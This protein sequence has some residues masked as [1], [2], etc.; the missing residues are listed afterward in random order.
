[1]MLETGIQKTTLDFYAS[2]LTQ[3]FAR[4][5][6]YFGKI[7]SVLAQ[8]SLGKDIYELIYAEIIDDQMVGSSYPANSVSV[9]NMQLQ[10]ESIQLLSGIISVDEY[11]RPKYMTTIQPLTGVPIGFIKAVPICYTIPGAA[12]KILSRINAS[13]FDLKQFNFDTDRLIIETTED[14]GQTGWVVYPQ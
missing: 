2:A 6:F 14:T 4:K 3:H 12:I 7:K 10:L 8:D 1:M 13:G 11:L 9:G 5:K